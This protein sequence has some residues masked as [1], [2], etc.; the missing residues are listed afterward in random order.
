LLRRAVVASLLD[1]ASSE[2]YEAVVFVAPSPTRS[3]TTTALG[4]W[5]DRTALVVERSDRP[6]AEDSVTALTGA[7]VDVVEVVFT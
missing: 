7:D 5:V 2:R 6:R 4:Q 3:A 1:R